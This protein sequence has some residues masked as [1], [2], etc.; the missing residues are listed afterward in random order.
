MPEETENY[1]HIP[2]RDADDFVE[3][4]FRTI[5]L[6]ESEGIKAVIGHLKSDPDGPTKVQK[7]LFDREKWSLEEAQ[8]WVDEHK[9]DVLNTNSTG[10]ENM[11]G[12]T[13]ET[14][15]VHATKTHRE[16]RVKFLTTPTLVKAANE[17]GRNLYHAYFTSD[18]QDEVGDII[19]RNATEKA[20]EKYRQ[21]GNVRYMHQPRAVGKVTRIGAGDGLEWNQVEFEITHDDV[22]R[23]I[24]AGVLKAM[25]V[26][27]IVN[28]FDWI[29]N[30]EEE[31]EERDDG[32]SKFF[33]W[34]ME[35]TD[36]DLVEIS[37]VD[38]PANYDAV[39]TGQAGD[40]KS[41]T[42]KVL[43]QFD[44]ESEFELAM[45]KCKRDKNYEV[46]VKGE[47][48]HRRMLVHRKSDGKLFDI[49][50]QEGMLDRDPEELKAEWTTAEINDARD[51][52]FAVVEDTGEKDDD[53]KTV[54]RSAR[55]LPHH[56]LDAVDHNNDNVDLPHYRNA[57]ARVNQIEPVTDTI[58]TEELRSKA[59]SHL[60]RHSSVLEDS[61]GIKIDNE[62][63]LDEDEW[64][65]FL[66]YAEGEITWQK[67][68]EWVESETETKDSDG[69]E[70]QGDAEEARTDEVPE[71]KGAD[72]A[73]DK[74]LAGIEEIKT[75][76]GDLPSAVGE[77]VKEAM[78]AEPA[79]PVE[80]TELVEDAEVT[81]PEPAPEPAL[82]AEMDRATGP[83]S[84]YDQLNKFIETFTS[85]IDALSDRI[86]NL[87]ADLEEAKKPQDRRAGVPNTD[88]EEKATAEIKSGMTRDEM[89]S[90]I[91]R[92]LRQRIR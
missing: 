23:D 12:V 90:E 5:T 49:D 15:P 2:V 72:D 16:S 64:G 26:G 67:W 76:L 71:E 56:D 24:D 37:V 36:Y 70:P 44:P 77:A 9:E 47:L 80:N 63:L 87:E 81:E 75:V 65:R 59:Q 10:G 83:T 31:E 60:D 69:A 13:E 32:K 11:D 45:Q 38:H 35:I 34:P 86:S 54:P 82:E 51:L 17:E 29:N 78:T 58:S 3:D 42:K 4:S 30:E 62:K 89:K 84:D 91:G 92:V 61:L 6:S 39:I 14:I 21:W 73:M 48:G 57:L 7:Y 18:A 43:Y 28:D 50:E 66:S 53:G 8:E 85:I 88:E 25:S 46:V 27:I 1:I 33:W 20:I 52:V 22:A 79:E 68:V 55:H 19:T 41:F 40:G 74:V